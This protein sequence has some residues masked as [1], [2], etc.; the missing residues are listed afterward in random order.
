MRLL[1]GDNNLACRPI[2][3]PDAI[4]LLILDNTKGHNLLALQEDQKTLWQ[5]YDLQ[6]AVDA[7]RLTSIERVVDA[8]KFEKRQKEYVGYN[9][10]TIHSLLAHVQTWAIITNI[11]KVEAKAR[12]HNLWVN[13]PDQHIT[14]FVR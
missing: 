2:P 3:N 7:C 5:K 13:Y 11:E 4:N 1:T 9:G 6:D 8:E 12:F 14:T 10:E